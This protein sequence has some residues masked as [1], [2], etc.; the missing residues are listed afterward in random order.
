MAEINNMCNSTVDCYLNIYCY[1]GLQN[2]EIDIENEEH[3]STTE[4]NNQ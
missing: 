2:V 1:Y 4:Q 3:L